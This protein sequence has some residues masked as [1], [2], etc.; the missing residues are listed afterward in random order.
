[1]CFDEKIQSLQNIQGEKS[2]PAGA[3][4]HGPK[5]QGGEPYGGVM[6]PNLRGLGGMDR[7]TRAL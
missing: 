5:Y 4:R 6:K 7:N 1:M 3:R 2:R